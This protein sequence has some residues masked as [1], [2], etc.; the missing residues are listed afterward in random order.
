MIA[1]VNRAGFPVIIIVTNQS[2]IARGLFGWE[3]FKAVQDEILARIGAEGAHV[4][5]VFACGYHR[6]GPPPLNVADHPWRKPGAAMLRKSA[7][8]FALDLARSY[9]VGDRVSD[10]S[11]GYNAGIA[12]GWLVRTGHGAGQVELFAQQQESWHRRR[13]TGDT[14]PSVVEAIGRFLALMA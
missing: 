1:A 3:D 12:G 8:F 10:L 6:C 5:A 11:A 14:A 9:I 7:E 2:G 4:D 13:F